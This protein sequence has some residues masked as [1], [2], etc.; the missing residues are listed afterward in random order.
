MSS[1]FVIPAR[2]L[3]HCQELLCR[4]LRMPRS[5]LLRT[6][7]DD[8]VRYQQDLDTCSRCC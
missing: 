5:G 2:I 3:Q 8:D 1:T 4:V 6:R 7:I